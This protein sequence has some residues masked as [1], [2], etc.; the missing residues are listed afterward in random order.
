MNNKSFPHASPD[1]F[2][3]LAKSIKAPIYALDDESAVKVDGEKVEV[4]S[5]GKYLVLNK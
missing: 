4:V 3:E 5:E 2:S 1:T